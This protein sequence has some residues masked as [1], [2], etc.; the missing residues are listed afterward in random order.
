[1]DYRHSMYA[2]Y[3]SQSVSAE[4]DI[5]PNQLPGS[6]LDRSTEILFHAMLLPSRPLPGRVLRQ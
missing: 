2:L 3:V 5:M 4:S 6:T 1:M